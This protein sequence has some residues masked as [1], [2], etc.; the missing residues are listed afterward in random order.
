MVVVALGATIGLT[1]QSLGWLIAGRAIQAFGTSVGLAVSRANRERPLSAP[2][3]WH[4]R[5]RSWAS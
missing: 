3:A 5:S 2:I 1:A 4:A